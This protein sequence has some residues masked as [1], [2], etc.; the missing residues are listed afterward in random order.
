LPRPGTEPTDLVGSKNAEADTTPD[1]TLRRRGGVETGLGWVILRSYSL[2]AAFVIALAVFS[3]AR[4]DIFPTS[5]NAISILTGGASLS[6]IALGVMIPLIVQQFDLT[7][8]YMATLSSILC[9]GFQ[10]FNRLPPWEAIVGAIAVCMLLGFVN[11]LLVA[12]VKLSSIIVTLATG[13]CLLGAADL[14]S[15]GQILFKNIPPSFTAIGQTRLVDI[16][17]PIIYA[18][19]AALVIWY[20]LEYRPVGRHLYAIGANQEAARLVSIK[21]KR[22]IVGAF[23]ASATLS[24][25]GGIVVAT[26]VG[27]AAPNALDYLLL[28][29]F[30]AVFLGATSIRPGHYNVWGTIIAVYLLGSVTTGMFMLGAPAFWEPVINGVILLFAVGLAKFS[31]RRFEAVDATT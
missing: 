12:H 29:A 19:A 25:L 13:S 22:L 3:I 11:G 2:L 9:I 18:A 5:Q 27:S 14:Y 10:S 7:P 4:P 15:G 21:V 26:Q 28:P 23:I 20:V 30:T 16:P 24:G 1:P 6:L 31:A 17:L 8:A